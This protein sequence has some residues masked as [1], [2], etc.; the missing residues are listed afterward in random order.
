M[1]PTF[2]AVIA[3]IEIK[4]LNNFIKN[5]NISADDAKAIK[6]SRRLKK[7]SRYNKAQ[8]EKK[9]RLQKSLE[10][11]KE[12]LRRE[13]EGIIRE[14]NDLRE[15]KLHLEIMQQLDDL[16]EQSEQRGGSGNGSGSNQ[17]ATAAIIF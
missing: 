16:Q 2:C 6:Y 5:N 13:Y 7:M 8:R 1:D 17:A 9:K 11:E 4:K 10:A 3:D 12:Q 14:V 15:A